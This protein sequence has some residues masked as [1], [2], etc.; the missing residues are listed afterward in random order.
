MYVYN[1]LPLPRQVEEYLDNHQIK[2]VFERKRDLFRT[3]PR[4]RSLNIEPLE[5]KD[6]GYN[7]FRITMKYRAIFEYKKPNLI[8]VIKI[9]NHYKD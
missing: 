1:F 9:T 3:S 5:P 2:K 8:Q 4:S 6:S 7:S